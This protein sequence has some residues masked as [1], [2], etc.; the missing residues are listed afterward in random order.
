MIIRIGTT[1]EYS[2]WRAR[3]A[4]WLRL[5][6]NRV[7]HATVVILASD[8]ARLKAQCVDGCARMFLQ[9]QAY[10]MMQEHADEIRSMEMAH[11]LEEWEPGRRELQ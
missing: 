2:T 10:E 8:N 7:D 11:A 6:A 5:A 4:R 1:P 3:L 9:E